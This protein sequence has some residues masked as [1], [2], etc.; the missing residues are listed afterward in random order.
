MPN[1]QPPP[2]GYP[3]IVDAESLDFRIQNYASAKG[4]TQL[5]ALAPGIYTSY[6]PNF[7]DLNLYYNDIPVAGDCLAK[8]Q[9]F[10]TTG[11]VCWDG[12]S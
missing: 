6:N 10:P 4:A 7:P 8:S 11:G 3:K 12:L 2:P 1:G 9:W 5:V